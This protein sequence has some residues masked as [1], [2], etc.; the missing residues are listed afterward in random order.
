MVA[1]G[2]DLDGILCNI[3]SEVRRRVKTDFDLDIS[4]DKFTFGEDMGLSE[5]TQIPDKWIYR[6][7]FK[8]EW[9]WAKASSYPENVEQ[10]RRW[11]EQGHEIYIVT[12]R[13]KNQCGMVTLGWLRR[14]KIPYT[15][16]S[17]EKPMHK[18]IYLKN[19]DIPIMFEDRFY[20]AN[21]C[22]AFGIRSFV[23]RRPWNIDFEDRV[24]NPLLT[25]VDNLEEADGAIQ[26]M[27]TEEYMKGK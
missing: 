5:Y 24:T 14:Y 27:H 26:D 15:S 10:I 18:V 19:N 25:F 11:G 7:L 21:K 6:I 20:E 16:F 4:E 22:A 17:F 8:D 13:D 2:C 23:V 12:G 3:I 9:F 1:I